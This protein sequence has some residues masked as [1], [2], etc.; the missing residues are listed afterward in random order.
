MA[1]I[2]R[3]RSAGLSRDVMDVN[4]RGVWPCCAVSRSAP[5]AGVQAQVQRV[6][7]QPTKTVLGDQITKRMQPCG[8]RVEEP[9]HVDHEPNGVEQRP[10]QIDRCGWEQ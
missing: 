6:L 5:R 8:R 9:W 7:D 10:L 4:S 1:K 3:G 2:D